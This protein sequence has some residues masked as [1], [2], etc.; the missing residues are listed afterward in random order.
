MSQEMKNAANILYEY[1]NKNYNKRIDAGPSY[2]NFLNNNIVF[3]K[4]VGKGKLKEF[5]NEFN[6]IFYFMHDEKAGGKGWI[7]I[8]ESNLINENNLKFFE[9]KIDNSTDL[10]NLIRNSLILNKILKN[11]NI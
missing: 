6:D 3:K 10:N 4:V 11:V 9:E 5:I 8:K 1:I 7:C 2:G